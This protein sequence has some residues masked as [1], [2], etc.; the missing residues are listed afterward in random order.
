MKSF[1][2]IIILLSIP[3]LS[4]FELPAN[5]KKL[6]VFTLIESSEATLKILDKN[7]DLKDFKNYLSKCRAVLIFPEVYEGGFIFGAKG[8]NGILLIKRGEVFTGPFFYSLG[9]L[10]FGLQAG[11][12]SGRVVMTVM[13]HRGLKS[14][15]KERV[16]LGVD[17]DAVVV[18]GG[19]GYSAESTIRLADIYSFSDNKGLF[20]GTSIEGSYL[21][22][23][24]DFNKIIHKKALSADDILR[25]DKPNANVNDL[26]K[27]ISRITKD[28]EK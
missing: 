10:S 28:V 9:G 23:R 18:E 16:K 2:K 4:F 14:I 8:G 1:K 26:K 12:K 11:A 25:A 19:V 21:Q 17:V 5:E 7:T 3:F 27:I 13:T 24:N 22:P 6:E 20:L 15:L